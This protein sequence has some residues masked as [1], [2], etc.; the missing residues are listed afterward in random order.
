MEQGTASIEEAWYSGEAQVV[1]RLATEALQREPAAFQPRAWL[2]LAQWVEGQL[3]AAQ[4]SLRD[5][6]RQPP[7]PGDEEAEWERHA[8]C[9]R[10][11]E[12][13]TE[14]DQLAVARFIVETLGLEHGT[15]LRILAEAEAPSNPVAALAFVR[16]A[17]A[18]DPADAEAHYLAA[19]F[20]AG[21]GKRALTMKH[22]E[23]ALEHGAGVLAVRVLARVDPEFDGLR[24]DAQFSALIDALPAGPTRPLYAA[25]SVGRLEEVIAIAATLKGSLDVLYPL[26][27]ALERLIDTS[28]EPGPFEERLAAV[29]D[30]IDEREDAGEESEAYARYCGET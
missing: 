26:R 18:A 22:L 11:V 1:M 3:S 25:L 17:I 20:F 30:D 23:A 7:T 4:A 8:V 21:L 12:V 13:A 27:E 10:L 2:G 16:R 14:G 29:N 6:F 15:S 24:A 9:N 28:A 5:A 19:K